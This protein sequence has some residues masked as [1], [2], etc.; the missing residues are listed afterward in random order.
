MTP[1]DIKQWWE[2]A[3][4]APIVLTLLVILVGLVYVTYKFLVY[5]IREIRLIIDVTHKLRDDL[6]NKINE[7]D[8]YIKEL[9]ALVDELKL[10]VKCLEALLN[11]LK[12]KSIE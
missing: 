6:I 3:I 7:Q 12:S 8:R 11:K 4:H 5:A 10:R 2:F 1:D 9:E